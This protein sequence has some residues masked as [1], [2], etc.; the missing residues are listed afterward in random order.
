[1]T[2]IKV[3]RALVL[4]ADPIFLVD[5]EGALPGEGLAAA[6]THVARCVHVL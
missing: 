2:H 5:E 1:M 6:W 4:E 3:D